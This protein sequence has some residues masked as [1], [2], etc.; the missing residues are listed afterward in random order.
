MAK[1][2]RMHIGSVEKPA[3]IFFHGLGGH[4]TGTWQHADCQPDDCWPHWVGQ[5]TDCDTW[6]LEYDAALSAWTDQAMALS[7]QGNQ[8]L[9]LLDSTAA[10]KG[11]ALVL[12]GHS[13]G[14]LVI[15]RL[16]VNGRTQGQAKFN[17][18]VQRVRGV[19]FIA[20]PHAGAALASL[21]HALR[22]VLKTNA[23]VGNMAAHDG[24]LALL[25]QQFK[26]AASKPELGL[27][28]HVFFEQQ[29]VRVGRR[30]FGIHF[31]GSM[32]VVDRTSA[33]PGL[34]GVVPV[35]IAGDHL[36]LCRP[37]G[38]DEQIHQSLCNFLSELPPDAC[39]A[40]AGAT[41][42]A[43][44]QDLEALYADLLRLPVPDHTDATPDQAVRRMRSR[45][46]N[47]EQ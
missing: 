5:S 40:E 9:D 10:L 19:V 42:L 20:T 30:F 39:Q 8:V 1:L 31:G 45:D 16:I 11:R 22:V 43:L 3:L 12:I 41:A 25:N 36:S 46:R 33:D 27:A 15:K 23:Q 38:R 18:L 32:M 13:M 2:H 44:D 28:A 24:D 37:A 29:G 47:T 21:A 26:H 17:A 4:W 34:P 7:P 6:S 14:G 35:P